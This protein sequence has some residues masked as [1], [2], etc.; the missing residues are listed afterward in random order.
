MRKSLDVTSWV[1]GEQLRRDIEDGVK[2]EEIK[3]AD[4]LEEFI[5]DC[6]G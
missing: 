1:K 6:K 5:A 2:P 3:V 4:A